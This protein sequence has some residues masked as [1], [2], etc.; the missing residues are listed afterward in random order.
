MTA[1]DIRWEMSELAPIATDEPLVDALIAVD[2]YRLLSQQAIH[3][4][5]S[6]QVEQRRLRERY[7][8]VISENRELRAPVRG[9]AVA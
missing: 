6:L 1:A 7:E 8:R 4:L 9:S 5:H 3:A 2:A